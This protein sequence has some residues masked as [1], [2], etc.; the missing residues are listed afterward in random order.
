METDLGIRWNVK[1]VGSLKIARPNYKFEQV[2]C[3]TTGRGSYYFQ[4]LKQGA[5]Q[6][7][8]IPF[9]M[10]AVLTLGALIIM[11]FAIEVFICE[12]YNGP[13]KDYLVCI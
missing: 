5:R 13:Y 7:V 1:G 6:L 4:K 3:D 8:Q 2:V 11:V 12:A 9:V 10:M